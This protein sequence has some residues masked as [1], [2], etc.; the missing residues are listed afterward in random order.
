LC[1]LF[2][3]FQFSLHIPGP[4]VCLSHFA[5]FWMFLDII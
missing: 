1:L 4:T 3:V 5:L 2:Y